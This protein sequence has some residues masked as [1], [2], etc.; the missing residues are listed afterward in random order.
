MN[1]LKATMLCSFSLAKGKLIGLLFPTAVTAFAIL[2]KMP[3]GADVVTV[4]HLFTFGIIFYSRHNSFC[5]ANAVSLKYR[6][7]SFAAVTGAMCLIAAV[8][9]SAAY[10]ISEAEQKFSFSEIYR[11]LISGGGV[12]EYSIVGMFAENLFYYISA[13]AVGCFVGS[14]RSVKGDRF[15][16]TMLLLT[17]AVLFAAV[18]LQKNFPLPTVWLAVLPALMLRGRF[19]AILLYILISAAALVSAYFMTYG[20]QRKERRKM[21]EAE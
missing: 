17:A 18:M 20:V 4:I 6:I 11:Y 1:R 16:L 5:T 12:P 15:A 21:R 13:V 9:T 3:V 19:T 2:M 14:I 7:Y 8:V 10:E